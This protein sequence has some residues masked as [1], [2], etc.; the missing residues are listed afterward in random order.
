MHVT[1]YGLTVIF[2]NTY[3]YTNAIMHAITI[4]EEVMK[5]GEGVSEDMEGGKGKEKWYN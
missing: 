1:L 2:R 5:S 3:V 4:D